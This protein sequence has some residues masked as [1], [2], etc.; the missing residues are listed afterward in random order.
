MQPARARTSGS[1][2]LTGSVTTGGAASGALAVPSAPI[3]A[4]PRYTFPAVNTG[5]DVVSAS[6][7]FVLPPIE[8]AYGVR[9]KSE[10]TTLPLAVSSSRL[11][12]LVQ[13]STMTFRTSAST[14]PEAR[15][16]RD[17]CFITQ[18]WCSDTFV[19][20]PYL[21][22]IERVFPAR[23]LHWSVTSWAP[24]AIETPSSPDPVDEMWLRTMS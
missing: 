19:V 9:P 6:A 1:I 22:K 15:G 21:R 2:S 8:T 13:S 18:R 10:F 23:K 24:Y 3:S 17:H 14:L 12:Q 5:A 7:P 4:M 11:P 16:A 20:P